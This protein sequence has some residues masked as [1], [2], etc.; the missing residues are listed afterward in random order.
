M[1]HALLSIKSQSLQRY[2]ARLNG[3]TNDDD[4]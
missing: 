3:D 4:K 1:G 2:R